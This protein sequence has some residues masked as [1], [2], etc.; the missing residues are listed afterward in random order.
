MSSGWARESGSDGD[1]DDD[2]DGVS[3]PE[4]LISFRLV[5]GRRRWQGGGGGRGRLVVD[6]SS[7]LS[8]V[9]Y[10]LRGFVDGSEGGCQVDGHRC[11]GVGREDDGQARRKGNETR[12]CFRLPAFCSTIF[13]YSNE[14]SRY[15]RL[16]EAEARKHRVCSAIPLPQCSSCWYRRPKLTCPTHLPSSSAPIEPSWRP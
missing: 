13:S 15:E 8:S 11:E 10:W 6:R 1:G 2:Y 4:E 9:R 3:L 16:R 14:R 7:T 5:L 12:D